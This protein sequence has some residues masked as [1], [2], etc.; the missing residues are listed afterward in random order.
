VCYFEGV[1]VACLVLPDHQRA[2]VCILKQPSHAQ[3]PRRNAHLLK[4]VPV[5]F[6][7]KSSVKAIAMAPLSSV[8]LWGPSWKQLL[9]AEAMLK[10]KLAA[11]EASIGSD[12]MS[13]AEADPV[14][15]RSAAWSVGSS[16]ADTPR[17]P[18]PAGGGAGEL[19]LAARLSAAVRTA[20]EK[21]HRA[22][23]TDQLHRTPVGQSLVAATQEHGAAPAQ[24]APETKPEAPEQGS[25]REVLALEVL[26][27]DSLQ[28]AG[29]SRHS[30][31]HDRRTSSHGTR[32][33][34]HTGDRARKT[35]PR[36]K[37]AARSRSWKGS[38]GG[39]A[40]RDGSG[41]AAGSRARPES[42]SRNGRVSRPS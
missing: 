14:S 4:T 16:A 24:L 38:V 40:K 1:A 10:A 25:Q 37:H 39:D 19:E 3:V 31:A 29:G 26:T 20:A 22:T 21:Q 18:E 23:A 35:T 6:G 28:G 27:V 13:R 33:Q 34:P 11:A 5:D 12:R 8:L 30:G 7:W 2:A 17:P 36:S 32:A 15:L 9:A 41:K 42:R